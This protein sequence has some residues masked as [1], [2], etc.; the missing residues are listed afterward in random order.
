MLYN[1]IYIIGVI[2]RKSWNILR[3]VPVMWNLN[4]PL[5]YSL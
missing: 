3:I 5:Y 4:V 1:L 2:S